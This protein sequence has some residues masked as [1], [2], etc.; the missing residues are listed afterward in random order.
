MNQGNSIPFGRGETFY[1]GA[2][3]DTANYAGVGVEGVQHL[4]ENTDPSSTPP[5]KRDATPALAEAVRNVSGVA[6]LPKR[7]VV[8]QAGFEHRR[9]DGYSR[10]EAKP[11]AGVVDDHLPA[12]GVPNGDIFW[13][14]KRGKFLIKSNHAADATNLWSVGDRLVAATAANST[15]TT[16]SGCVG[17]A[18]LSGATTPLSDN[19]LNNIGKALT[20]RTTANTN[21]DT[22]V[23]CNFL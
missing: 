21:T 6:L 11:A 4:F 2:T 3:I 18:V 5:T 17:V 23:D 7:M 13:L 16:A 22:L 8:Y 9:V 15:A 14:L 19:I 1:K 20:A 10:L 12:A